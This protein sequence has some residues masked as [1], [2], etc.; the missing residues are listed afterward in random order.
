MTDEIGIHDFLGKYATDVIGTCAFG[1]KLD[2]MTNETAK[3]RKYGRQ[4]F[5]PTFRL[6]IVN[7]LGMISSQNSKNVENSTVFI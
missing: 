6:L 5:K 7:I 1:L 4:L 3:F 2:S